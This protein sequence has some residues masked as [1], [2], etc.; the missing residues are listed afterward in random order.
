[1]INK[2]IGVNYF[3]VLYSKRRVQQMRQPQESEISIKQSTGISQDITKYLALSK[4]KDG[5]S[6]SI[7]Q[8]RYI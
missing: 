6:R 3:K 2:Q 5:E 7:S 1:M 4:S 8:K